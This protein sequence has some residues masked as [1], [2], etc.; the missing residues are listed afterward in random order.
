MARLWFEGWALYG[1]E[2]STG[3]RRSLPRRMAGTGLV[4]KIG[5][6]NFHESGRFWSTYRTLVFIVY[7]KLQESTDRLH[8]VS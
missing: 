4:S 2:P 3:N 8:E 7:P 5:I 6:I 1:T